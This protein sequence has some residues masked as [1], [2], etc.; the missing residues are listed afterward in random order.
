MLE[1]SLSELGIARDDA[2]KQLAITCAEF[3]ELV[4]LV[5]SHENQLAE[6]NTIAPCLGAFSTKALGSSSYILQSFKRF[7]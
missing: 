7:D 3:S 1:I 5:A 4:I 6:K 2:G